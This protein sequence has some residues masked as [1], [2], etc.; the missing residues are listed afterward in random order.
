LVLSGASVQTEAADAGGSTV[1][2]FETL[3]NAVS[4]T[5]DANGRASERGSA[6][7]RDPHGTSTRGGEGRWDSSPAAQEP[8]ASTM[9]NLAQVAAWSQPFQSAQTSP[10]IPATTE[11]GHSGAA[12]D[13]QKTLTGIGAEEATLATDFDGIGAGAGAEA[14]R[15]APIG[16]DEIGREQVQGPNRREHSERY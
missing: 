10:R 9:P 2:R 14:G 8:P 7:E 15:R 12:P 4:S 1:S 6:D 3:S 5:P 16:T 13:E 11:P